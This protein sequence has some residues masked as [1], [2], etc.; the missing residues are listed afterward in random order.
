[1]SSQKEGERRVTT[2]DFASSRERGEKLVVVATYDTLFARLAEDGGVDAVLVGDSLG[3]V[4]AGYDSTIPVT[5]DQMIYHGGCVRRGLRR[6]MLIVDMPFLTY[7]V[8]VEE[9]LRNCGRVVQEAGADYRSYVRDTR[10]DDQG[11]FRFDDLPDGSW[12]LIAP[13][14]AGDGDPVVLMQRVTTGRGRTT[15]VTLD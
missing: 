15:A 7:Q 10:C 8:S 3:N 4:V 6:A 1:M 2:R 5:L 9:A 14:R 11:R 13:V 12:F